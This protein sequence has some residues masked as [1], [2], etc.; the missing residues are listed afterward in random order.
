MIKFSSMKNAPFSLPGQFWRGN[1]HTHCTRSDGKFTPRQVVERYINA[2]YDFLAIT[3]H[4][5]PDYGFPITDT[6]KFRNKNFTTILGAELHTGKTEQGGRWHILAVGLPANFA[7][8]KKTESGRDL[9][10][11]ALRAGAFVAVA[12]PQWYSLTERD[13]NALGMVDSIEVFNGTSINYNDRADSWHIADI[14]L[15]RGKRYSICA[16]DDF[17]GV[18]GRDDFGLG[19]VYVKSKWLEPAAL[20]EALKGGNFYSSCGPQIFNIQLLARSKI[21][22]QCS[23]AHRIFATGIGHFAQSAHGYGLTEATLSIKKFKS[24][25]VRITVKDRLGRRAWSNPIW[26]D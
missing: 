18:P 25:Y 26:L 8:T 16:T 19:W 5:L 21:K 22:V 1:I 23:S 3:D 20:V 9:A 17:H 6:V 13:I 15:G 4:F 24:P 2:G 7:P 10:R 11:R 12:H 14:M